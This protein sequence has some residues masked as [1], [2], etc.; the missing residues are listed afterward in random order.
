MSE[1]EK[2]VKEM[3]P[4]ETESKETESKEIESTEI[5]PAKT[6]SIETEKG[7]QEAAEAKETNEEKENQPKQGRQIRGLY[8]KV[9]ISVKQLNIII[10]VLL[11]AIVICVAIG[12][13]NRGYLVQFN[14]QGGTTV[15]ESATRKYLYGEKIDSVEDPTREGYSFTGWYQDAA[16]T[17]P[18]DMEKDGV[19]EP[20]TLYA[21]WEEKK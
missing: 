14:S 18:W 3:E 1:E 19:I 6:E 9:K 12:L 5:E 11:I 20:M 16:C 15:G 8:D 21:G 4:K 10:P 2:E 13:S 17:F 7:S